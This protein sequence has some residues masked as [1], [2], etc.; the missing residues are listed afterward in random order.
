MK[1]STY[2]WIGSILVVLIVIG[3]IVHAKKS[4]P[5]NTVA[6]TVA[7]QDVKQTVIATGTV[8]SQSNLNL[9]FKGTG[10]ISQVN[11]AVGDKVHQGQVLMELDESSASTAIQ[12]AKAGVVSAQANYDKVVNGSSADQI[13]VQQAAVA[14]AQVA[15]QNAQTAYTNTVS[16]QQTAVQNAQ[17]AEYNAGLTATPSASNSSTASLTVNGTYTGTQQGAYNV[18]IVATGSGNTYSYNGL[19]SG[20][21]TVQTGIPLPLGK[22]GL[23]LTFSSTGIV[24]SGDMWTIQVPNTQSPS[25]LTASNNYQA[26]LQTQQQQVTNAQ[27]QINSAQAALQQAQAQLTLNKS[28]ALPADVEAA[29]GQLQTAQ[30]G[31]AAAQNQYNNNII[32]API[33]GTISQVNGT[34]G[35]APGLDPIVLIDANSLHVESEI[36][37][38]SIALVQPGQ[39]IDMT[40][41]A[42]GPDQ[43]FTGTVLSID[44]A[45]TVISGVTDFRVVSSLPTPANPDIKT[46]LSVNLS[47]LTNEKQD[48]LAVPNRLLQSDSS[49]K[50]F[51][52]VIASDGKSTKSVYITTGLSGDTYTEVT[53]GLSGGEQIAAPANS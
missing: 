16:Q 1:R 44:P 31:L 39:T 10:T 19:E 49:G 36:S 47:I 34:I 41:D 5:K 25:Y 40:F 24:H 13:A 29:E 20:S 37:E 21:G 14:A 26:A 46:G 12:Q 2:I 23:F 50:Q 11:V 51:V 8:T 4:K 27:N 32:T 48:V 30:A 52:T 38:S 18:S 43:H 6:Y 7:T 3:V 9:G 17:T 22:L 35:A 45:S 15:V 53:S 42:F 28:A 33:D